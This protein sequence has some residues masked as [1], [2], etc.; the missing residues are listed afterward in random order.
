MFL[1]STGVLI[2]EITDE[3]DTTVMDLTQLHIKEVMIDEAHEYWFGDFSTGQIQSRLDKPVVTESA[4]KY[5]TNLK[6]LAEYPVHKQLN[7]LIDM[8]DK[9]SIEKTPE[10]LAMKQF[11]DASRSM[12]QQK[13]ETFASNETAYI[14]VSQEEEQAQIAKKVV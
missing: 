5:A 3:M 11:L 6:V 12:H 2:G 14:F 9:S 1:K 10:F 8:F 13:I 4:V 7:I